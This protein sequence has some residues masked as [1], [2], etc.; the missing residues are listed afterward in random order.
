[1]T[2]RDPRLLVRLHPVR[3]GGCGTA[4]VQHHRAARSLAPALRRRGDLDPEGMLGFWLAHLPPSVDPLDVPSRAGS[5]PGAPHGLTAPTLATGP[6][7]RFRLQRAR[8]QPHRFLP[9]S[10]RARLGDPGPAPLSD[11]SQVLTPH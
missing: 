10:R 2:T 5:D 7:P 6:A 1:R 11:F 8:G 9:R 3:F 4:D